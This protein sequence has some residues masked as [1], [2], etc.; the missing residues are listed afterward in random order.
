MIYFF[1]IWFIW[2]KVCVVLKTK[3]DVRIKG[4]LLMKIHGWEALNCFIRVWSP[5][6]MI[7]GLLCHFQS[8]IWHW[9]SLN[10]ISF[11]F[12]IFSMW[13]QPYFCWGSPASSKPNP[14]LCWLS[15][16]TMYSQYL[17]GKRS[18]QCCPAIAAQKDFLP[19]C[20]EEQD[21]RLSR[22]RPRKSLAMTWRLV[23]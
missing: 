16:S 9:N 4:A 19:T 21:L 7:S 20:Q 13:T 12:F 5:W 11:L 17:L 18:T 22:I 2:S 14:R 8:E 6:I 10:L 1:I 3:G 23:N 15:L